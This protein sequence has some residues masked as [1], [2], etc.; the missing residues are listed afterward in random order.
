MKKPHQGIVAFW[1]VVIG[2][3]LWSGMHGQTSP[4]DRAAEIAG[5]VFILAGGLFF[6]AFRIV[7]NQRLKN[8]GAATVQNLSEQNYLA[9]LFQGLLLLIAGTL[10][11]FLQWWAAVAAG[12]LFLIGVAALFFYGWPHTKINEKYFKN[13]PVG[14]GHSELRTNQ[15]YK[16]K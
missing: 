12:G 14:R 13:Q 9:L 1:A 6:I 7:L 15:H 8:F 3:K 4:A 10:M 2:L 11:I 5:F 16:N